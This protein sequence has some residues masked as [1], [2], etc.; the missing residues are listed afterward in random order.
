M[1]SLLLCY[2]LRV[3]GDSM[4]KCEKCGS[5]TLFRTAVK[6]QDNKF[7]CVKCLKEL[8][9]EHP[10]KEAFYLSMHTSEDILHPEIKWARERVDTSQCR[11]G[12]FSCLPIYSFARQN[13]TP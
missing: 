7:I 3:G 12:Y 5:S 10:V 8:G 11:L 13:K 1:C 2:A 6:F 4:A 9:H